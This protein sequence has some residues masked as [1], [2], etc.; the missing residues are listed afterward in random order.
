MFAH[1]ILPSCRLLPLRPR[2]QPGP[3]QPV[4]ADGGV[5][6]AGARPLA[7]PPRR[8]ACR[9]PGAFPFLPQAYPLQECRFCL[10]R[11]HGPPSAP[12]STRH[13]APPDT[14][15]ASQ[16]VSWTSEQR[17]MWVCRRRPC[18]QGSSDVRAPRLPCRPPAFLH[19]QSSAVC[20]G[21]S[22]Q[23]AASCLRCA[24]LAASGLQTAMC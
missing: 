18:T 14:S 19:M 6:A 8:G 20:A 10:V 2:G 11:R 3:Q 5:G 12:L 17:P 21:M 22:V 15:I 23:P 7:R 1:Q 13:A 9:R 4:G 24:V 16:L